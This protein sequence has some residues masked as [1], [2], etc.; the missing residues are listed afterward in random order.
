MELERIL[1]FST[2][3]SDHSSIKQGIMQTSAFSDLNNTTLANPA[4]VPQGFEYGSSQFSV[5]KYSPRLLIN[6]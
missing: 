4:M 3:L 6:S 1:R 2:I 5:H